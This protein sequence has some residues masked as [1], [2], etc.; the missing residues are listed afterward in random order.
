M[1]FSV[2]WVVYFT[3][4]ELVSI[5]FFFLLLLKFDFFLIMLCNHKY[6]NRKWKWQGKDF[7]FNF[8]KENL[9]S[10]DLWR[11]WRGGIIY[12]WVL[13]VRLEKFK[14][15]YFLFTLNSYVF[16]GHFNILMLKIIFLKYKIYYF[17]IFINKK[18]FKKQQ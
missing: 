1:P 18:Y 4:C 8:K 10:F 3:V 6:P 7:L 13:K 16:Y 9:N 14:F 2:W 5:C 12:F 11:S 15:F 17:N